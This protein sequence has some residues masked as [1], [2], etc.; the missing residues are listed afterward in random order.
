MGMDSKSK[1]SCE[2]PA[3]DRQC[4]CDSSLPRSM[5]AFPACGKDS[6][7]SAGWVR[8]ELVS[9]LSLWLTFQVWITWVALVAAFSGL[10]VL[11]LRRLTGLP[12]G[13]QNAY[14][15]VWAGFCM[16]MA[17]LLVWHFFLPVNQ[18]ALG[19]FILLAVGSLAFEWRWFVATWRKGVN[20]PF[21]LAIG[22]FSF[23][24]ANH[25]LARGGMDD[26]NY[27]FQAIRWFHDYPIVPGLA[28]LHGRIGFN[29]A[30]HLFAAMMNF[31]P[32]NGC[33]NHLFNGLFTV[34]TL[35]LFA[36]AIRLLA[37]G[38]LSASSLSAALV[39]SPC[40]GLVLFGIFGPMISTLKADVFVCAA[41]ATLAVLFIEF[42]QTSA[43]DARHLPL[44]ATLLLL[45]AVAFSIKITAGVFCGILAAAV[46]IRL[47]ATVGWSHR[48]TVFATLAAAL[49][50]ASVL[51]RGIILSGYPMY[52]APLFGVNVDWRVPAAQTDAE[53]A[54]ITSWAQLRPTYDAAGVTGWTWLHPWAKSTVLTDKFDIVLPA[55]L[56]L[57]SIPLWLS[58]NRGTRWNLVPPWGWTTLLSA[59]TL[60]LAV[61]FVQAPAGRFAFIHFWV[62]FGVLFTISVSRLR[63]LPRLTLAAAAAIVLPLSGFLLF[64]IVGIPAQFRAGMVTLMLFGVSWIIASC[65]AVTKQHARLLAALC[66]LLGFWQIGD[67]VLASVVRRRATQ[68]ESFLWLPIRIFP[69]RLQHFP[70]TPRRTYQGLTVFEALDILYETPLPNTHYFNPWL[71]L[72]V[73]GDLSRGFRN[74]RAPDPARYGYSVR[75]V[76][77]SDGKDHEI[78]TPE[79]GSPGH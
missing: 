36:D 75:M 32:W 27:E 1:R 71:E 63:E 28:N 49:I 43:L 62:L 20:L 39:V 60:S 45:A 77:G 33:P 26:Y 74:S 16:L 41:T 4:E 19:L 9:I 66:L 68:A 3:T 7:R 40:I 58:R 44:G 69:E 31:G 13:W 61:W 29:N 54:F 8:I 24:T 64:F 25:A 47:V 70:Y 10:G 56:T 65:W 18:W 34:L 42:A 12:P 11:C 72:R 17:G 53:R 5:Q 15:A 21:S 51:L 50:V 67:R 76:T 14:L 52:P 48:V 46:L 6:G 22:A 38:R 57:L 37:A 23:W 2:K 78:I 73:P 55:F 35:V 59:S 79:Q 30:H